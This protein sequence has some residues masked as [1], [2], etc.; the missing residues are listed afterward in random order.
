MKRT[1]RGLSPGWWLTRVV[2]MPS[3]W[4]W[5]RLTPAAVAMVVG[6][7]LAIGVNNPGE[8]MGLPVAVLLLAMLVMATAWSFTVRP[9]LRAARGWPRL[10]V[11]GEP[12]QLQVTLANPGRRVA[13]GV[14]Y[15]EDPLGSPWSLW[16]RRHGTPRD[17]WAASRP[18]A[19]PPV[20]PGGAVTI[21]VQ[22]TPRQRGMLRIPRGLLARTDPFGLV[23]GFRTPETAPARAG[24]PAMVL[25][26]PRRHALPEPALPGIAKFQPGGV[27]L[28][29][30]VG[31]F[32]EFAALRDYRRGDARKLIHW[33]SS[34]RTGE[35]V[36]KEFHDE[37]IVRHCLA[38]DADAGD[39]ALFEDAVAVAASFACTLP[40]QDSLLDLLLMD[41]AAVHLV[42]GRRLGQAQ[43][44]LEALA[45]AAMRPGSF[46]DFAELVLRHAAHLTACLLVLCVFD[47]ARRDLVR[48]LRQRGVPVVVLWV[49]AAGR[50]DKG[51]E[52]PA[53][54]PAEERPDRLIIIESGRVGE[55]L[56]QIGSR[57]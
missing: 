12:F 23:R 26:L 47:Q 54:L 52:I 37:L 48:A 57:A 2:E 13:A 36:V 7:A 9:R 3:R 10:A 34:A 33:R 53:T 20:P 25:V 30:G 27:A 45:L 41:G 39:A 14:T 49:V 56:Q 32:E 11:C 28:A 31:Q 24:E 15:G 51:S 16:G 17:V 44:M 43:P 42:S 21:T 6:M 35:L 18:V 46:P 38:L 22:V 5:R 50:S 55:D 4:A 8:T 40:D 1:W 19:V 29:A